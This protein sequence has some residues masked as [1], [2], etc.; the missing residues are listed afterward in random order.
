MFLQFIVAACG[1][2]M[3]QAHVAIAGDV[4]SVSH[5][6][7][8]GDFWV[9]DASDGS[10]NIWAITPYPR[11][12]DWKNTQSKLRQ[13]FDDSVRQVI[14]KYAYPNATEVSFT[15]TGLQTLVRNCPQGKWVVYQQPKSGIREA[16]V[17]SEGQSSASGMRADKLFDAAKSFS[18]EKLLSPSN[19]N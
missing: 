14:T 6:K 12:A 17:A 4:C 5:A 13:T 15:L 7:K 10:D 2:L 16:R 11:S 1:L 18:P 3:L 8:I 9:S 19:E